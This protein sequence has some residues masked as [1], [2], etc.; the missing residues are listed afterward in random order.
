[1]CL[2]LTCEVHHKLMGY[3]GLSDFQKSSN[4]HSLCSVDVLSS[5]LPCGGLSSQSSRAGSWMPCL[6]STADGGMG[7]ACPG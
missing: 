7:V 6:S 2:C 4:Y 5:P 1:M 3:L